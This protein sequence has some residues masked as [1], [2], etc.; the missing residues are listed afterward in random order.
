MRDDIRIEWNGKTYVVPHN[1]RAI[2]QVERV[3]VR[4]DV[5]EDLQAN[6]SLTPSDIAEIFANLLNLGGAGVS[7]DDVYDA[8]FSGGASGAAINTAMAVILA[9]MESRA[10]PK[11]IAE[12]VSANPPKPTR[13]KSSP[14]K[15]TRRRSARGG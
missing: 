5:R 2:R 7:H 1:L 6:G 15:R 4:P 14:Q 11:G 8:M 9:I 13:A 3:I 10:A 12:G